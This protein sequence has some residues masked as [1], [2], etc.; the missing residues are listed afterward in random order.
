MAEAGR[1]GFHRMTTRTPDARTTRPQE[2]ADTP[3]MAPALAALVGGDRS[4]Q[5]ADDDVIAIVASSKDT[6]QWLLTNYGVYLR[7]RKLEQPVRHIAAGIGTDTDVQIPHAQPIRARYLL[8]SHRRSRPIQIRISTTPSAA[9]IRPRS[10][11][12]WH[13]PA[14]ASVPPEPVSCGGHSDSPAVGGIPEARHHLLADLR[15]ATVLKGLQRSGWDAAPAAI[16]STPDGEARVPG[17]LSADDVV[18]V[19]VSRVRRRTA[20]QHPPVRVRDTCRGREGTDEDAMNWG[21]VEIR[22]FH[23]ERNAHHPLGELG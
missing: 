11:R 23:P 17:T 13:A 1:R 22:T 4:H 7:D 16:G 21:N 2:G 15:H 5:R 9:P 14:T 19:L 8:G 6:A 12:I 10:G 18:A 3:Q 20:Q